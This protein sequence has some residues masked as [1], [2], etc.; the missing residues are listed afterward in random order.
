VLTTVLIL[1]NSFYSDKARKISNSSQL[2]KLPVPLM[3]PQMVQTKGKFYILS[4]SNF[5]GFLKKFN[6][7]NK[8]LL[9]DSQIVVY[10]FNPSGGIVK[11]IA[12]AEFGKCF[13]GACCYSNKLYIAGGYDANWKPSATLFEF[14]LSAKKWKQKNSMFIPRARFSLECSEG[15]IYA[16]GGEGTNGSI[17]IYD[18]L[19]DLWELVNTKYIPSNIQPLL[20]ISSSAVI[21]KKVFLLG[22]TGST[23]HIFDPE[24]S[25]QSE[26]PSTP[27]KSDYFSTVV[28][29]KRLYIAGGITENSI[30]DRVYMYDE[31]EGIWSSVGKIPVPRYGAGLAYYSGMLFY[32]GGTT[33]DLTKPAEPTDEIYIYRP[34][35]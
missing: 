4:Q 29:N 22:T 21:D 1:L 11:K 20:G 34:I 3:V 8:A 2:A 35:K 31:S 15:F 5:E 25:I 28:Y 18:P 32:L 14:D 13:F 24:N 33:I 27:E 12:D 23:F 9:P 7:S 19:K 30:N 16:I 17:E 10:E 26:G 6:I